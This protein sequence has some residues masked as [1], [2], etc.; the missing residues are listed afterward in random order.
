MAFDDTSID[1]TTV[2][3]RT[4]P[5]SI[6]FDAFRDNEHSARTKEA[7]PA[8]AVLQKPIAAGHL[9]DVLRRISAMWMLISSLPMQLFQ[10]AVVL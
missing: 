9:K 6:G 3:W 10:R 7:A 8:F 4:R 5:S 2:I 1:H